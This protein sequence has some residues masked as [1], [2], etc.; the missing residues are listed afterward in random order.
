MSDN[1][2]INVSEIELLD[3]QAKCCHKDHKKI[4]CGICKKYFFSMEINKTITPMLV[5]SESDKYL[6]CQYCLFNSQYEYRLVN[7]NTR[8]QNDFF[9]GVMSLNDAYNNL[10]QERQEMDIYNSNIDIYD[11]KIKFYDFDI[12]CDKNIKDQLD[13]NKINMQ[14]NTLGK[15]A[16]L[17]YSEVIIN[18]KIKY[19]IFC[20]LPTELTSIILNF[21]NLNDLRVLEKI[22]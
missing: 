2:S 3:E 18:N 8:S 20:V 7:I 15:I 16:N 14:N 9:C 1:F 5:S 4:K 6:I 10:I 22:L 13:K 12:Q 17:R 11:A 19:S 21:L